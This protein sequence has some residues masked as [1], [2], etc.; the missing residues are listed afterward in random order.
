MIPALRKSLAIRRGITLPEPEAVDYVAFKEREYDRL[1]E[2]LR[3]SLDMK[4]IYEI[5]DV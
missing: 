4:K 3:S 1:A 2:V 5:L